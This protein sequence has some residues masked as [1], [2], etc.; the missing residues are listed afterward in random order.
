MEREKER[1]NGDLFFRVWWE[2]GGG[3]RMRWRRGGRVEERL[4]GLRC[5]ERRGEK[6]MGE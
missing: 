4:D 6:A 2:G 5:S 3:M 1:A